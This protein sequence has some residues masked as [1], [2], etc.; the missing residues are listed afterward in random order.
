MVGREKHRMEAFIRFHLTE[1]DLYFANCEPDFNV[2]PLISKHFKSRYADQKWLIFD[3]KRGFGIHYDLHQVNEV[4]FDFEHENLL[5]E[6][7]S[8]F[9]PRRTGAKGRQLKAIT[10]SS[11]H[12]YGDEENAYRDMWYKYFKSTNIE[13]RKNMALHLRHVPKRYWK[14]LSEKM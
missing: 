6:V 4:R 1:D 10:N 11:A 9:P 2:L 3:L 12:D 8:A 14:Y 7:D 5:G 13:E